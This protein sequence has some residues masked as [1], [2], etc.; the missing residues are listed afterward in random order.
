[1]L[2]PEELSFCC[3]NNNGDEDENEK[4]GMDMER[5][6]FPHLSED[7]SKV[8]LPARVEAKLDGE[9]NLW[10]GEKLIN[11]YGTIRYFNFNL[12]KDLKIVG[13]LYYGDG[14]SNFYQALPHLKNNSPDLKFQP[15]GL[16]ETDLPYYEQ[17]KIL[18]FLGEPVGYTAYSTK[19]IDYYTKK[20]LSEGYE[21]AVIKP[22]ISKTPHS[23][24]KI[25]KDHTID[26]LILGIRK[27]KY[28][29][30]VGIDNQV[31]GHCTLV[32]WDEIYEKIK[33]LPIKNEDKENFY[34]ESDVIVEVEY[35]GIIKNGKI[36]LRS[37]R[38]KR[39]REDLRKEDLCLDCVF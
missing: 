17:L 6:E 36:S 8:K 5:L 7:L 27:N 10:D 31:L 26:L 20:F 34:F 38:I 1:M 21:G 23:W 39:I 11:R 3:Y 4:G 19:E 18:S 14:K 32:G 37:P 29:V 24:I 15:F 35:F 9:A 2:T 16:W 13:E 33:D 28:S 12:P 30:A 22:L 25:K